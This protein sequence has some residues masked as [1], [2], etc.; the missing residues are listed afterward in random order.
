M[1]DERRETE[2]AVAY[3]EERS[4]RAG[5]QPLA[6][7]A[8]ELAG[9]IDED[10]GNRF[11]VSVDPVAD[12]HVLI[13]YG[14]DFARLLGLRADSGS[15]IRLVHEV[16]DRLLPAFV[17]GCRTANFDAPPVRI[18]GAAD[19]GAGRRQLYR[20]VF[21]PLGENLVLGAFNSR[22]TRGKARPEA[23]A[24]PAAAPQASMPQEE[25]EAAIAAFIR[26]KGI[27]RCPTAFAVPTTASVA[28]ADRRALERHAVERERVRRERTA[29][30]HLSFLAFQAPP[31]D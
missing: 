14:A 20:A 28:A 6:P 23:A 16:P 2:R 12:R 24:S 1:P 29:A 4:R 26:L 3:W 11:I 13:A 7:T 10:G 21:M 22:L 19:L 18:E 9:I 25:Y 8:V 27:T 15:S 5:S 31:G 30:R 17:E